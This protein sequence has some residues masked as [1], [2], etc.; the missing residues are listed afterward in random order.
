MIL[1]G[2]STPEHDNI[3]KA[4][5]NG[6]NYLELQL[7]T[8]HIDNIEITK[9]N[10]EKAQQELKKINKTFRIIS[11]HTPHFDKEHPKYLYKTIE[12]SKQFKAY[13]IFHS[14]ELTLIDTLA[15]A[16]TVE[17]DRMI[18]ENKTTMDMK[19]IVH[20]IISTHG[21]ALDIAHLYR[22]SQN[23]YNDLEILLETFK[24]NIKLIHMNDSTK[25]KDGLAIGDGDI[26]F[27]TI[28]QIIQK[29]K[30]TESMIIET[31]P[32]SQEES[33]KKIERL[34]GGTQK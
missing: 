22:A 21:L 2:K 8:K 4:V 29:T 15:I 11:I 33:R 30:Y 1:A 18:L 28:M 5:M 16:K 9:K 20:N 12:F 7:D 14:K 26:D 23:I 19:S 32:D 24:K 31:P 27:P 34:I 25:I 10:I 17:S 13:T 6:F 3:T